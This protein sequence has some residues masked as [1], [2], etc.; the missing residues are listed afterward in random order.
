MFGRSDNKVVILSQYSCDQL[1]NPNMSTESQI[2]NSN[3]QP[4]N[5][6][7]SE[8]TRHKAY[9]IFVELHFGHAMEINFV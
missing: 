5:H 9:C 2:V 8:L 6:T 1:A 4:F 3:H 7:V